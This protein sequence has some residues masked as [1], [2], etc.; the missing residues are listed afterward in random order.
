MLLLCPQFVAAISLREKRWARHYRGASLKPGQFMENAWSRLV[1]TQEYKDVVQA[2]VKRHLQQ[3]ERLV[4]LIPG[5]GGGVVMLLH[6]PPGMGRTLTAG[7]GYDGWPL[8]K[9]LRC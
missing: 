4:D 3:S 8:L 7:W 5:K 2:L 6:G 9:W 1:I